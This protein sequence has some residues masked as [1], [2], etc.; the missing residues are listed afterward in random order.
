MVETGGA[1]QGPHDGPSLSF[2]DDLVHFL[3]ASTGFIIV[4]FNKQIPS[5]MFKT[6][7]QNSISAPYKK[8]I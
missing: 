1:T 2:L 5:F 7:Y 3:S 4:W 6:G 8:L